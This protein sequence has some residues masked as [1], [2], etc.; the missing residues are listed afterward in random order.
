MFE[1]YTNSGDV[2]S[3]KYSTC[4]TNL[5]MTSSDK[6]C[7]SWYLKL[8]RTESTW[9]MRGNF[10]QEKSVNPK[11]WKPAGI[12]GLFWMKGFPMGSLGSC[13]WITALWRSKP[14]WVRKVIQQISHLERKKTEMTYWLLQELAC[15]L[16]WGILFPL[17]PWY[18]EP[19]KSKTKPQCIKTYHHKR[20]FRSQSLS[21]SFWL[22]SPLKFK[23]YENWQSHTGRR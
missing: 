12:E 11:S 1:A 9:E 21:T 13:L 5:S 15:F 20:P 22:V 16:H 7:S 17:T 23:E 4:R 3:T 2:L 18:Q 19:A 6:H 10:L 14:R 8:W